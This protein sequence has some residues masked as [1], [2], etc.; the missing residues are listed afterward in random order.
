MA[1]LNGIPGIPNT[2]PSSDRNY[3]ARSKPWSLLGVTKI[4]NKQKNIRYTEN[5]CLKVLQLFTHTSQNC[6]HIWSQRSRYVSQCSLKS[7]NLQ[8]TALLLS[9]QNAGKKRKEGEKKECALPFLLFSGLWFILRS[10]VHHIYCEK[11]IIYVIYESSF[12]DRGDIIGNNVYNLD[13]VLS[14]TISISSS[15]P[16][17]LEQKQV[18]GDEKKGKRTKKRKN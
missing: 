12:G 2:P 5:V 3:A 9:S 6:T 10:Q 4:K 17:F 16:H 14:H 15:K 13:S 7:A 18:E 11:Y 1:D 8:M